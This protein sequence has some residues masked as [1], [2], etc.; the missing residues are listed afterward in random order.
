M[1]RRNA[2]IGSLSSVDALGLYAAVLLGAV[3][4]VG[5]DVL[6]DARAEKGARIRAIEDLTLWAH[7]HERQVIFAI[8]SLIIVL[9]LYLFFEPRPTAWVA[10]LVG[11]S[12]DSAIDTLLGRFTSA[13]D[14]DIAKLKKDIAPAAAA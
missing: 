10:L 12:W 14:K 7:V 2:R 11:Y 4:H 1:A 13:L 6:K 3:V 8:L 5:V 9:F